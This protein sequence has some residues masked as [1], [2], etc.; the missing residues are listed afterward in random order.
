MSRTERATPF[1]GEYLI[2]K[3]FQHGAFEL[4]GWEAMPRA[5]L[6]VLVVGEEDLTRP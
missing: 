5:S 2:R 4:H 6:L 3:V 1:D